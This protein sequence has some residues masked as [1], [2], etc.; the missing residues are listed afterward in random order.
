MPAKGGEHL[1]F[2]HF[3]LHNSHACILNASNNHKEQHI[4]PRPLTPPATSIPFP[5]RKSLGELPSKPHNSFSYRSNVIDCR[6]FLAFAF[7]LTSVF[8][9]S[10]ITPKKK[11]ETPLWTFSTPLNHPSP[12][13]GVHL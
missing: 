3:L 2:V 6:Q 7:A 1:L 5:Y 13:K 10:G 9:L 8:R 11:K 4:C 12:E